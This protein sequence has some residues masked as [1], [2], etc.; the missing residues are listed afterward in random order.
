MMMMTLIALTHVFH[1][2]V[3]VSTEPEPWKKKI[4]CCCC[5]C[6]E[7]FSEKSRNLYGHF[8]LFTLW[9]LR[10]KKREASK[11]FECSSFSH[12]ETIYLFFSPPTRWNTNIGDMACV[13][14]GADRLKE[15]GQ[16]VCAAILCTA[17]FHSTTF[18]AWICAW[19]IF[20]PKKN[21]FTS[22]L[23]S[24]RASANGP[25]NSRR[26]MVDPPEIVNLERTDT[27]SKESE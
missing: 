25:A 19:P 15:H 13:A 18:T 22:F 23:S 12:S 8:E 26:Q 4:C 7:E 16:I 11:R 2:S 24:K 1:H 9:K 17:P 14:V 27:R 20:A 10:G 3:P 6:P 5:Y 21:F